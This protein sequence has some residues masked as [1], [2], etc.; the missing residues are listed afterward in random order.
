[1]RQVAIVGGSLAGVH[2]AESLRERGFDGDLAII[3]AEEHLPYDRPPLSKEALVRDPDLESLLLRQREWYETQGIGLVLGDPVVGLDPSSRM[4]RLRSGA[5]F[6]YDR[7]IIATGSH[8]RRV[9]TMQGQPVAHVLRTIDDARSLYRE[10][11]RGRRLLVIGGGVTGLEVAASARQCG[12]EVTVVVRE[13]LPLVR[14]LGE[15]VGAWYRDLHVRHGV[16]MLC[17]AS[18]ESIEQH[19]DAAARVRLSSGVVVECDVIVA[20]VGARPAIEWLKGS[21]VR[22][23]DGI[24]CQPDLSTSVPGVVAAGDVACWSNSLFGR[25]MRVEH[26]SNAVDQGRHVAGTLV[27]ETDPFVSVPYFWTDQY[28]ARM[29]FVGDVQAAQEV[30]VVASSTK[31]LIVLFGRGGTIRGAACVNAPRDLA[32]YRAAIRD[33]VVWED[34]IDGPAARATTT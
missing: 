18:V 6:A 15:T 30:R 7:L 19:G 12:M 10:F 11:E 20:G 23:A 17:D 9:P 2:A 14:A 8:A 27:G 32:R 4:L 22:I 21:G 34:L 26:W 33:R 1:M 16:R 13:R 29:R 31:E 25:E 5:E 3:C 24:S 28:D